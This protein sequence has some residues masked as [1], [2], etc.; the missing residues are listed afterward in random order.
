[1]SLRLTL[2]NTKI[3]SQYY[4]CLNKTSIDSNALYIRCQ[5]NLEVLHPTC[6]SFQMTDNFGAAYGSLHF[7]KSQQ[8]LTTIR[9]DDYGFLNKF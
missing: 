7:T 8:R 4:G 5:L 9:K 2:E 1:M 3:A 6:S